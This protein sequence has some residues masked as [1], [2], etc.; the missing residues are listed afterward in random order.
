MGIL[1]GLHQVYSHPSEPY[2]GYHGIDFAEE[3]G[4]LAFLMRARAE[5]LRDFGFC[6]SP[7]VAFHIFKGIETPAAGD[8]AAYQQCPSGYGVPEEP[9]CCCLGQSS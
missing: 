3:F 9:F 5:G 1:I 7:A 2:A 8:G 6:M 4:P